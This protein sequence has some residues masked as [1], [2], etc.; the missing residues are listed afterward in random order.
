M[1]TFKQ[2]D[3][4][5]FIGHYIDQS[6]GV[7]PSYDE[8]KDALS[9]KS[10]SGVNRLINGLCERGFLESL[11]HHRRSLTVTPKGIDLINSH[12]PR[13]TKPEP[14]APVLFGTPVRS[15]FPYD[16]SITYSAE[17]SL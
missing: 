6:D 10:K 13:E 4:L 5:Q 7:S 16:M 9:L 14:P 15:R 1:L 11:P 2:R 12:S 3:C 17:A 8:I